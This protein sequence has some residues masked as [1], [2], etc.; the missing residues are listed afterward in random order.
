M[1]VSYLH[2]HGSMS[3]IAV[4]IDSSVMCLHVHFS[5]GEL[6]TKTNAFDNDSSIVDHVHVHVA[7][8]RQFSLL[9]AQ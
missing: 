6:S 8:D 1:Y 5:P 2:V 7:L 4:P 9:F 3:I